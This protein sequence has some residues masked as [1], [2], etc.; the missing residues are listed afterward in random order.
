MQFQK[1]IFPKWKF[2]LGFIPCII[3]FLL[4]VMLQG[5]TQPMVSIDS[6]KA[7]L[8][9]NQGTKK[10]EILYKIAY[11]QFDVDNI[12]AEQ[13][14]NEAHTLA[15][16]LGDSL[17]I[18]KSGRILGQLI[19]RT[20]QPERAINQLQKILPI[21]QRNS[22]VVEEKL[23]LNALAITYTFIANYDIALEYH[24][25]SLKLLEQA[26]DLK[27]LSITLNNIGLIYYKL[28]DFEKA[29]HFYS[30]SLKVKQD[31]HETFDLDIL[32]G[33]IALCYNGMKNF[34]KAEEYVYKAS[35][36]CVDKCS[37][38]LLMQGQFCLGLISLNSKNYDNAKKHF[39]SA[40]NYS[41][42]NH[43]LRYESEILLYLGKVDVAT[44]K[45]NSAQNSM[46]KAVDIAKKAGNNEM[47]IQAYRELANLNLN[48]NNYKSAFLFQ[49]EYV[50]LND[51]I[52]NRGLIRNV[53]N[54]QSRY[55][56]RSNLATIK[57]NEKSLALQSEI[58]ERQHLQTILV[59]IISGLFL[60]IIILLYIN[61]RK[62]VKFEV[63][64]DA[65]VKSRTAELEA[66]RYELEQ[67]TLQ[68][69]SFIQKTYTESKSVLATIQGIF[70]VATREVSDVL[71]LQYFTKIK[72]A[73]QQLEE[74]SRILYTK[75]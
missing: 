4:N 24:F 61:Y 22:F 69:K 32:F 12:E 7:L 13:F 8:P 66:S 25:K 6:L 74:S 39:Q 50:K 59:A 21:A 18:T 51:S 15:L 46:A 72:E 35:K 52:Y 45:L 16:E 56:E 71:A 10:Y 44:Q 43:D 2:F 11:E 49:Q 5:H 30:R 68:Q 75:L 26:E 55:E 40:L 53:A 23:I 9:L 67:Y 33:N 17:F 37:D 70:S 3:F 63:I 29:L 19:R 62:K 41:R 54:I 20:N 47:L 36:A 31:S 60:F 64:L 38:N 48:R 1:S 65:R 58:I 27:Q 42:I 57:E 14:A 73:T 34:E 28:A